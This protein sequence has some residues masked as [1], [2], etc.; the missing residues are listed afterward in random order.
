MSIA[1]AISTGISRAV[2]SSKLLLWLWLVN[3]AVALPVA[4][5]MSESLRNSI[6]ASLVQEKLRSGFDMGW[7]GEFQASAKG[8]ETTFTPTVLGAGAFYNNLE[9]W[10]GGE[11]FKGFP[12]LVGLGIL[13]ALLWA[14]MLGGILDRFWKPEGR[15]VLSHFL[16]NGGKYFFRFVRLA[17]LSGALYY[18]VYLFAGWLL[19]GIE[20]WTRDVTVEQTVFLYVLAAAALVVFLLC[21]VNVV[22]DYAKIAT[23]VESRRSMLLAAIRGLGFVLSNPG[24]TFGL[25]F[26]LGLLGVLLLALYA[27]VAPGAAESTSVGVLVAFAVGQAYLMAKLVLRLSFFGGEMAIY[28]FVAHPAGVAS[29]ESGA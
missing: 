13:Y 2:G 18:V 1:K 24:K 15:F 4:W 20:T 14:F 11:L 22:F 10:F 25:Y 8:V 23:V 16:G 27:W 21:F 26:G 7:F 17:V 19:R 9:G 29:S 3:F 5:V 6:G 28:D 12:G